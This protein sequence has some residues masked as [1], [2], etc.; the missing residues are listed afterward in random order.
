MAFSRVQI[1]KKE[2]ST[3]MWQEM[4]FDTILPHEMGHI[5][6]RE[7]VGYNK[8]LPLWLDEGVA[9]MQEYESKERLATAKCLVNLKLYT[10]L[11]DLSQI[12]DASVILIVRQ[13][14]TVPVFEDWGW[15][16]FQAFCFL[17]SRLRF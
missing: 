5:I 3:Y 9:C 14:L 4:L 7:F 15:R 1:K 6:F 17:Q 16:F 12:K 10:H 8:A 2:I 13:T 11:S